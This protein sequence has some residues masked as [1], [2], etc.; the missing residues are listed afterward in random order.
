MAKTLGKYIT[1]LILLLT[2][3]PVVGKQANTSKAEQKVDSDAILAKSKLNFEFSMKD[4]LTSE[5]ESYGLKWA[6]EFNHDPY[7]FFEGEYKFS[8]EFFA[9]NSESETS[10]EIV[11][12]RKYGVGTK[13]AATK[14]PYRFK[15]F[16]SFGLESLKEEKTSDT[17]VIINDF[18]ATYKWGVGFTFPLKDQASSGIKYD[19]ILGLEF[20]YYKNFDEFPM[21]DEVFSETKITLVFNYLAWLN[22]K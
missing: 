13:F 15:P 8:L 9:E 5:S 19:P 21:S 4:T 1:Y 10:T 12:I 6:N 11:D 14:T 16:I 20:G 7:K 2:V 22:S 3:L 18:D 17:E